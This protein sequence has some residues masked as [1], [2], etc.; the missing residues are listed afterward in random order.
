MLN[1]VIVRNTSLR[2]SAILSTHPPELDDIA[3]QFRDGH[4]MR[5]VM[6]AHAAYPMSSRWSDR[7]ALYDFQSNTLQLLIVSK[8]CREVLESGHHDNIEFLPIVVLDHRGKVASNDYFIA[9]LLGSVDCMDRER[10]SFEPNPLNPDIFGVCDRLVLQDDKIPDDVELF[11]LSNGPTTYI[12]R[13][14]LKE[15]LEKAGI[16]GVSFIPESQYDSALY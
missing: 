2:D 15:R 16:Q 13:Q 7:R 6:P 12:A 3:F 1:Y 10:S 9:H 4:P 11:R 14:S 5:D 8:R